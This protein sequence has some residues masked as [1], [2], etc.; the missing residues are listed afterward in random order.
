VHR[1]A[2]LPLASAVLLWMIGLTNCGGRGPSPIVLPVLTVLTS[3][4]P[5]AELNADYQGTLA[6]SSGA[7]GPYSWSLTSDEAL[8]AGLALDS[9]TGVIAGKAL[10]AGTYG[11][12]I[13][14]VHD[15]G[16]SS[17]VSKAI[18][19]QVV[20]TTAD[21]CVP[22]GSES[23]LTTATPYA[24]LLQGF[25]ATGLGFAT[26][27]SF[28][29]GGDGT[30]ASAE[31][32]YNGYALANSNAPKG[33]G[34]FSVNLAGSKYALGA[35]G[36]GCLV[37]SFAV[38][39]QAAAA[40]RTLPNA[41]SKGARLKAQAARGSTPA[42]LAV[43]FVLGAKNAS[44]V[45]SNG[46]I[47]EFD[48]LVGTG[49]VASGVMHLQDPAS[50]SL[51]A[52]ASNYA[53]GVTSGGV[54]ERTSIAGIFTN[55]SG[56]LSGGVANLD[57]N[58][59]MNDE[60]DIDESPTGGHGTIGTTFSSNGRGTM[61]YVFDGTYDGSTYHFTIYMANAS[62]FFMIST[63][64]F[65]FED[66]PNGDISLV[67][68]R[69]LA[70][71]S[72]FGAFP[73]N[74][75]YLLASTGAGRTPVMGHQAFAEIATLKALNT[76]EASVTNVVRNLS[77][78]PSTPASTDGSYVSTAQGQVSFSGLEIETPIVYLTNGGDVGES[79]QGFAVSSN[80]SGSLGVLVNQNAS[81]P[82][83]SAAS[84]NGRYS[85]ATVEDPEQLNGSLVY[86]CVF[87]GAGNFNN[88]FD[89]SV[90]GTPAIADGTL[91][92]PYTVSPDGSG[93][94]NGSLAFVTNGSQIYA[95]TQAA[96]SEAQLFVFDQGNLP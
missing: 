11:P 16:G 89:A 23:A 65:D 14:Q 62:D 54:S 73:L 29:P 47:I 13:F 3:T 72:S 71:A 67:S 19:L 42:G 8:P 43:R 41:Q 63:D 21:E 36:R 33:S 58:V 31:A 88:A 83:F 64:S 80:F 20:D 78:T 50:F 39:P 57:V 75:N 27:G 5:A 17:A 15:A 37:L 44:G 95:I 25:D 2:T 93:T 51:T 92:G 91:T 6:A 86:D 87:D 48:D 90:P 7:G 61:D 84:L 94:F 40:N 76:G 59:N 60:Y 30:I 26:A 10:A 4:L 56:T 49:S 45:Y 32:D 77:G 38:G 52:L 28:T 96:G 82:N 66:D 79:I 9:A 85:A 24:F 74:G 35:D 22:R 1:A 81:S 69:A 70:T 34:H 53:F 12:Y 46:R 68:G 18:T 55:V